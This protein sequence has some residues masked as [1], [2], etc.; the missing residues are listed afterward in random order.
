MILKIAVVTTV[1]VNAGISEGVRCFRGSGENYYLTRAAKG[2]AHYM[3]KHRRQGHQNWDIR[4]GTVM[5]QTEYLY[6]IEEVCAESWPG[7]DRHS[8][9][10]EMFNS[11]RQSPGHWQAINKPC[12]I[13]GFA[14][15]RGDNGV[16]YGC[17]LVGR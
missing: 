11:W 17:G 5:R 9:A 15:A 13:Y 2:H 10:K 14:M 8:A 4:K 12:K 1:L 6:K 16:W 3:A 7:Q